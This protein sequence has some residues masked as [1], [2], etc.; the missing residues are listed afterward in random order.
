MVTLLAKADIE[1]V[2]WANVV[3]VLFF[4]LLLRFKGLGLA[5]GMFNLL[6]PLPTPASLI[7]LVGNY[8]Y[9]NIIG[10]ALNHSEFFNKVV[11]WSFYC[12]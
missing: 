12:Y 3:C 5:L 10:F 8:Y 6:N 1:L 2:L 4:A 7:V 9:R 11:P